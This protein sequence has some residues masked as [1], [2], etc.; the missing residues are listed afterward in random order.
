[1]HFISAVQCSTLPITNSLYMASHKTGTIG[2]NDE[3][4][5]YSLCAFSTS[6]TVIDVQIQTYPFS[7]HTVSSV[8]WDGCYVRLW[9]ASSDEQHSEI[10]PLKNTLPSSDSGDRNPVGWMTDIRVSCQPLH[11]PRPSVPYPV[12]NKLACIHYQDH[13]LLLLTWGI[14]Y[15]L[16]FII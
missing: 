8:R 11:R 3:N 14:L 2:K 1:M 15:V 7:S 13:T 5:L 4:G 10:S 12:I 16:T 9:N 6:A